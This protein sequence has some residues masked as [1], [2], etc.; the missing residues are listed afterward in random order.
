[1]LAVSL[2]SAPAADRLARMIILRF[3]GGP[4][5]ASDCLCKWSWRR[6]WGGDSPVEVDRERLERLFPAGA[7]DSHVRPA[8]L[9]QVPHGQVENFEGG[10]LGGELPAV[11]G[12]LP[13]PGVHALDQVC[14]RYEIPWGSVRCSAGLAGW[15]GIRCDRPGQ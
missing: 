3:P 12:H 9:L 2:R 4:T 10:L 8:E 1:M 6:S 5:G 15:L 14:I 11:A 7:A 13:Q